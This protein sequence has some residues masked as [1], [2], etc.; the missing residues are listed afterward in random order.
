MIP[1][2]LF[3]YTMTPIVF[4]QRHDLRMLAQVGL[5]KVF[6]N[7]KENQN[8]KVRVLTT[9]QPRLLFYRV[10]TI[11]SPFSSASA[12]NLSLPLLRLC[13]VVAMPSSCSR[14]PSWDFL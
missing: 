7:Q 11:Y 12:T 1:W 8:S 3:T 9:T 4:V 2:K 13:Q 10:Y 14:R 5:H 6:K